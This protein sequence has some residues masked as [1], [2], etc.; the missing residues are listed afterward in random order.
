MRITELQSKTDLILEMQDAYDQTYQLAAE[1]D[2]AN[3]N[4]QPRD[5]W[6]IAEQLEHLIL[7]S[8]GVASALKT[9]KEQLAAFGQLER[10]SWKEDDFFYPKTDFQIQWEGQGKRLQAL[11]ARKA[12]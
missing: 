7:S 12:T 2:A 8:K 4:F 3:F 5:R 11:R 10:M 9:P 6:S 1:K